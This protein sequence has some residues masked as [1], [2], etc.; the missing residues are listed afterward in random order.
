M[1][2]PIIGGNWKM[3]KTSREA[4][5]LIRNLIPEIGTYNAVESVVF[6]PFCY[7][8]Q[9]STLLEG[10]DSLTLG[11]QNMFWEE[12]GAYTGE[13]SPAILVDVECRYV[14]L[15][16]SERR[17]YF[18]DND[19]VINRKI[20]AAL[21]FGLI[22]LV[23]V[24]ER[25]EERKRGL[26]ETIVESQLT[27][28]FADIDS[29]QIGQIV[30]AYEPVWAIGTGETATPQQAQQMHKFI[31]GILRDMYDEQRA[32]VVRIQYGGSVKPGNIQELMEQPDVDGALVGGASLDAPSFVKIVKYGVK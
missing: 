16:H 27:K 21:K 25:F 5:D 12:K 28:C 14:I 19:E 11:A 9:I 6:P 30:I 22:P 4:E 15:G 26:A 29:A 17:E 23:C 13:I 18:S 3:N 8:K 1:R 20:K 24:G 10:V 32:D 2:K 7:L 31:R